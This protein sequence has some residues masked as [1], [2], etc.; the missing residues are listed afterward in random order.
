MGLVAGLQDALGVAD[1]VADQGVEL[2]QGDAHE[3]LGG[4]RIRSGFKTVEP[5]L[6][7]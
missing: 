7:K 6:L 1:Q 4:G 5:V 3:P 2:G